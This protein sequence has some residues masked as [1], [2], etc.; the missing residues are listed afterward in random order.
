MEISSFLK[1]IEKYFFYPT[2][3]S[4]YSLFLMCLGVASNYTVLY[5]EI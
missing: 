2:D 5:L 3:L 1:D 4:E